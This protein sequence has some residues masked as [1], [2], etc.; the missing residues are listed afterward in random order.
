MTDG[1]GGIEWRRV[2]SAEKF[3]L[4]HQSFPSVSY[5][6]YRVWYSRDSTPCA[7][8][9]PRSSWV[10]RNSGECLPRTDRQ[11]CW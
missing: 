11:M 1:L 9:L 5:E 2:L 8:L 7:A 10:D 6:P 3:R 4:G